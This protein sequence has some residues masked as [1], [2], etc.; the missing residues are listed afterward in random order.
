[1]SLAGLKYF[2]ARIYMGNTPTLGLRRGQKYDEGHSGAINV[3][4]VVHSRNLCMTR[5]IR[6]TGGHNQLFSDDQSC[7]N[8]STASVPGF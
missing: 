8:A 2:T 6:Q 1:M 3:P 5:A 4:H 7:V